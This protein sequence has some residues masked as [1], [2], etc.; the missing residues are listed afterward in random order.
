MNTI[1]DQPDADQQPV[2]P[3]SCW[4]GPAAGWWSRAGATQLEPCSR[5][6][7]CRPFQ[8][9][10]KLTAYSG[11]TAIRATMARLV[12]TTSS[13]AASAAQAST[14]AALITAPRSVRPG[15]AS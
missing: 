8:A 3:R 9:N 13:W 7:R 10:T 12:D 4:P 1:I 14:N 11:R 6:G 15:V 2:S 5:D